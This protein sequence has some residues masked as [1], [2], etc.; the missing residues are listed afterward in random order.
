MSAYTYVE[1]NETVTLNC[2]ANYCPYEYD[3]YLEQEINKKIAEKAL[4]KVQGEQKDLESDNKKLK[5]DIEDYKKKITK[6]ES[7]IKDNEGNQAKK[8]TEIDA[9]KKVVDEIIKQMRK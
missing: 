6:A 1:T 7:D 4:D 8:K 5:S 2:G 9:Q 3:D